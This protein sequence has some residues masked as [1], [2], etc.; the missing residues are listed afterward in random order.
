MTVDQATLPPRDGAWLWKT[1]QTGTA[2]SRPRSANPA[3]SADTDDEL[4]VQLVS[5]PPMIPRIYPGL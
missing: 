4:P 2:D 5:P 1:G 3:T